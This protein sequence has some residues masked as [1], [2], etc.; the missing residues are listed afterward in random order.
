VLPRKLTLL[1]SFW[2]RSRVEQLEKTESWRV[3]RHTSGIAIR[4]VHGRDV[5]TLRRDRR[6]DMTEPCTELNG[7][8]W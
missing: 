1:R 4:I 5:E 7:S 3:D 2:P 8:R 6:Q